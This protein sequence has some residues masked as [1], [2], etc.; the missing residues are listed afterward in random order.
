MVGC[1]VGEAVRMAIMV[2]EGLT[3][4]FPPQLHAA[5]GRKVVSGQTCRVTTTQL[6]PAWAS[7][8]SAVSDLLA[9]LRINVMIL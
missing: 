3:I 1:G 6:V 5:V 8:P 9:S 7:W 2:D 4:T